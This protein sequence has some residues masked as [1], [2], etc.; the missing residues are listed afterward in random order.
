MARDGRRQ[1]KSQKKVVSCLPQITFL[2][3]GNSG[4]NPLHLSRLAGA[5]RDFPEVTQSGNNI[6][7]THA[8]Q[9]SLVAQ[10]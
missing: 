10:W 8:S 3:E 7:K 2:G 4:S 1:S 6:A 5:L 9:G